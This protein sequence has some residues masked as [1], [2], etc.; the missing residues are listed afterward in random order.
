M[1]FVDTWDGRYFAIHLIE[2]HGQIYDHTGRQ[3]TAADAGQVFRG[4][5]HMVIWSRLLLKPSINTNLSIS[6]NIINMILV[7]V[8]L[9][10]LL[11]LLSLLLLLMLLVEMSDCVESVSAP[12]SLLHRLASMNQVL[13]ITFLAGKYS[14]VI[15][16]QFPCTEFVGR[17][18]R[19]I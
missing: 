8:L 16:M 18:R 4:I 1:L 5:G 3:Q 13:L 2:I 6:D 10:L 11:L 9:L 7:F 19:W 12:I 17:K 14:C 15:F